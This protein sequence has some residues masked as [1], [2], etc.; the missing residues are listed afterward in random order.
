MRIALAAPL[1]SLLVSSSAFAQEAPAP[2]P[3]P[4]RADRVM[5]SV[6]T[7]NTCRDA[8]IERRIKT[9]ETYG[10][11]LFLIPQHSE[12]QTWEQVCVAPCKVE[13]DRMSTYR[14]GRENW[15]T[16][17]RPFTLPPNADQ[18]KVDVAPG[19]FW[20]HAAATRL[21]ATGTA[22]AIVGGAL[23]STAHTWDAKSDERHV[24][25]AGWITGAIGLGLLA[26]GIPIAIL[27]QTHVKVN[28]R[29]VAAAP[30]PPR[31]TLGGLVF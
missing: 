31:L 8:V 5:V 16:R 22:A 3:P 17:S 30:P 18:V 27:T 26:V 19:N 9:D 20:W 4:P 25:N 23:L 11:T 14:V 12:V 2:L 21:I 6:E 28:E 10:R 15:V 29:K 7:S 13:M 24:R 1:F